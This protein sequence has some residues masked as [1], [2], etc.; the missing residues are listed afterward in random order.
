M[1]PKFS[2]RNGFAS[3]KLIFFQTLDYQ[4]ALSMLGINI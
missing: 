3:Q 1:D 2:D 4:A